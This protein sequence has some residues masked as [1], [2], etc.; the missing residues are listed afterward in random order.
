MQQ[1]EFRP[2]LATDIEAVM[3]VEKSA[4]EFPWTKGIFADCLRVGYDCIIASEADNI[5]G[6]AVLSVAADES[7]ILN[8]TVD[9]EHQ[10]KGIGKQLLQ[11][12]IDIARI[13]SAEVVLLEARPSNKTAIHIYESAGFNEI[14]CRKAYYPAPGGKEDALIFAL[15]L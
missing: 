8:L 15:Q 6:H 4:Y 3:L 11:H 12:L 13:K 9:R 7:H 2:M 1:I 14:G 5:I 10:G